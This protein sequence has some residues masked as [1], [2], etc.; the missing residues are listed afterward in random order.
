MP[1]DLCSPFLT[2]SA[3]NAAVTCYETP[4]MPLSLLFCSACLGNPNTASALTQLRMATENHTHL[5]R[6]PPPAWHPT[7]LLSVSP[8]PTLRGLCHTSS[9]L[10]LRD[11][12]SGAHWLSN[13]VRHKH[14]TTFWAMRC[15][16]ELAGRLLRK[17]PHSLE[18]A[19][20]KGWPFLF[21]W[22][23]V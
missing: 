10:S 6:A 11:F 19:Q 17:F 3:V 18:R 9:S 2:S 21:L 8:F 7:S 12:Y 15:E 5:R 4:L 16:E 22:V 20:E 14:V 23:W 1:P 13:C